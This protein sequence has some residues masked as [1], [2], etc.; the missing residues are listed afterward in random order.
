M[1]LKFNYEMANGYFED[2][3]VI[4]NGPILDTQY[5]LY[6]NKWGI[7]DADIGFRPVNI[8]LY[9]Y[10]N[11]LEESCVR[12]ELN[13]VDGYG[14]TVAD[15]AYSI[16]KVEVSGT[17]YNH[18]DMVYGDPFPIEVVEN[19]LLYNDI[20]TEKLSFKSEI[21]DDGVKVSAIIG[22]LVLPIC[23][24]FHCNLNSDIEYSWKDDRSCATLKVGD[25]IYK[26][27]SDVQQI[28]PWD[29][30]ADILNGQLG[31]DFKAKDRLLDL[32]AEG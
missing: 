7:N 19:Y 9:F 4:S 13:G 29:T 23:L 5:I 10:T 22:E 20:N 27:Y 16:P 28:D 1:E 18:Y 32:I 24:M 14:Y 31:L 3:D 2:I 6:R 17:S 25:K 21:T 12:V 26:A 15:Y 11:K 8:Q 30:E